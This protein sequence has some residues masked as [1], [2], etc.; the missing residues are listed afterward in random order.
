MRSPVCLQ[1]L[2]LDLLDTVLRGLSFPD[3][4]RLAVTCPRVRHM[5]SSRVFWVTYFTASPHT[6]EP[7]FFRSLR[8]GPSWFTRVITTAP[9]LS[10]HLSAESLYTLLARNMDIVHSAEQQQC[11]L[12]LN[13]RLFEW[14]VYRASHTKARALSDL[15]SYG[16]ATL[17]TPEVQ[18]FVLDLP[19]HAFDQASAFYS[20]GRCL[21]ELLN[22]RLHTIQ[23]PVIQRYI[24]DLH[25]S[26]F[27]QQSTLYTK[28]R[29][30][31]ELLADRLGSV[32][33][34]SLQ[35]YVLRMPASCFDVSSSFYSKTSALETLC[36]QGLHTLAS[37]CVRRLAVDLFSASVAAVDMD[38]THPF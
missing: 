29:S 25:P 10:T 27:D 12:S 14:V 19:P 17:H 6:V 30:L 23:S 9:R 35:M 18:R 24:L 31:G 16:M 5:C 38:D 7:V 1:D 26:Q 13:R 33:S 21:S 37:D 8:A 11:V 28:E 32:S 20:K 22:Y 4:W 34:E 2:P 15:L 3:V 36:R